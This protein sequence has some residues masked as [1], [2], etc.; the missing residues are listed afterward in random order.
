MKQIL[1][2][3]LL[4]VCVNNPFYLI[5]LVNN[6]RANNRLNQLEISK[7][8]MASSQYRS[9]YLERSGDWS[10]NGFLNSVII[11]RFNGHSAGENLAKDYDCDDEVINAWM[12][13][14]SH[15]ANILNQ[16]WKY[17]GISEYKSYRV[18]HFGSK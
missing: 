6:E 4:V 12:L 7:S 16:K 18:I 13:S 3:L 10:H 1:P 5:G 2:T 14:P 17:Y 9:F 15:K 11:S 8:L